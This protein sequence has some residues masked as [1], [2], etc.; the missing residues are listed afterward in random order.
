MGSGRSGTSLLRSLCNA[1][2]RVFVSQESAVYQWLQPARLP[3]CTTARAWFDGYAKTASFRLSGLD[4]AAI[5][6]AIPADLPRATPG[7]AVSAILGASAAR[8]GRV[9]WGDKT[10][11]HALQLDAVFRDFPDARVLAVSRHPVPT[12]ASVARMPWGSDSALLNAAGIARVDAAVAKWGDRVRAVKLEDLVARPRETMADV[13]VFIGEDWDDRVLDHPSWQPDG[14]GV[15]LPWFASAS[16]SVAPARAAREVAMS[17]EAVALVERTCAAM[18]ARHGYE[19]W[20][21]GPVSGL[22]LAGAWLGDAWRATRFLLRAG[23][24]APTLRD[25]AR[26]DASE[27]LRWLFGLNPSD[28]VPDEHRRIPDLD[29]PA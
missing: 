25:P 14:G 6:E 16:R 15:A 26:L 1:H 19:P 10:P 20:P 18:M 7:P 5:R 11:L 2:P 8:Y 17:D 24:S 23:A 13:L 29:G 9:R 21:R 4:P 28:A 3:R 27:Q 12:A 22:A